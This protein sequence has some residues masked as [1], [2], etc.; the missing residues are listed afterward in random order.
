[1]SNSDLSRLIILGA[2]ASVE[3][4]VY[5]TGAQLVEVARNVISMSESEFGKELILKAKTEAMIRVNDL[6]FAKRCL[7]DLVDSNHA[8]I[9]SHIS[10]ID[11]KIDQNFLKSFII[12]AIL[13]SNAYSDMNGASR[14][15]WYPE[16]AKIIFPTLS[17]ELRNEDKNEEGKLKSEAIKSR[18]KSLEII[19]FNYDVSLEIYL[20]ERVKKYFGTLDENAKGAFKEICEKIFHVYGAVASWE[21]VFD[22]GRGCLWAYFS[23]L[24]SWKLEFS[25]ENK[26][27]ILVERIGVNQKIVLRQKDVYLSEYRKFLSSEEYS[28]FDLAIK[29]TES[30]TAGIKGGIKVSD[31]F[32]ITKFGGN[33]FCESYFGDSG[34]LESGPERRSHL[35]IFCFLVLEYALAINRN[36]DTNNSKLLSPNMINVISDERQKLSEKILTKVFDQKPDLLYVLGYGFDETNNE[37]LG[38]KNIRYQKGCFATNYASNKDEV[39]QR[40]QRLILDDLLS[41]HQGN[42]G[43]NGTAPYKYFTPLISHKSVSQA[44]KEDFSLLEN[45]N[46]PL[47]IQTNLTP[48]LELKK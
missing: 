4:G 31:F 15:N 25:T 2:G 18:L 22:A 27:E 12:S 34:L 24:S 38:L 45:P 40:L 13:A 7:G 14:N 42:L 3:C 47:V 26:K 43:P 28:D 35:S 17:S 16:L 44:L 5:P 46:S 48:Y 30:R 8:S 21:Q 20:L 37:I 11:N 1:M 10:Y 23:Y 41:R 33:A 29:E 19:T 36:L 6:E 39:N 32:R 9:D